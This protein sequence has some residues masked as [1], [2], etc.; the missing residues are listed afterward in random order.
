[1]C[2]CVRTSPDVWLSTGSLLRPPVQATLSHSPERS[3]R[4]ALPLLQPGQAQKEA[5]HNEAL[6][7]IDLLL[8][9]AI[10][11]APMA[12]P[13]G[14]PQLGQ[15]W[16]VGAGATDA[17]AGQ[18]T[19]LAAWTAGGWRFLQPQPGT[20]AWNKSAGLWLYWDGSAWSDGR[21][22]AAGI[23]ID[24]QQVVGS[25][26]PA[27][28]SPS[29]GTTIDDEARAALASVIVALQTHGLID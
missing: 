20:R 18:A 16:I 12:T 15:T 2:R 6:T 4:F 7:A 11:A 26:R 27:I 13:P 24:G 14:N 1:M 19:R 10:E 5:F 29:G 9:A 25:R 21:L 28:P 3:A 22:P 8:E 17:W 23:V